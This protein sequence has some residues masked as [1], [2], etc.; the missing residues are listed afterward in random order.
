LINDL[1]GD[2]PAMVKSVTSKVW[3]WKSSTSPSS[4]ARRLAK[5]EPSRW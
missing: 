5:I 3:G 1:S 2:D 4:Y